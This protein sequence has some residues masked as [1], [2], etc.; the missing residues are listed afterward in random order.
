MSELSPLFEV[1]EFLDK[2]ID[3]FDEEVR[4]L[5]DGSPFDVSLASDQVPTDLLDLCCE[6]VVSKDDSVEFLHSLSDVIEVLQ[7]LRVLP[8]NK[9]LNRINRFHLALCYRI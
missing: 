9:T 2:N 8:I 3:P 6:N 4:A 7:S 5:P 1:V